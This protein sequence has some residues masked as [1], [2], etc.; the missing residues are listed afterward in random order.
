M[1]ELRHQGRLHILRHGEAA[2]P[3]QLPTVIK[4]A[5]RQPPT[6]CSAAPIPC[7]RVHPHCS[8]SCSSPRPCFRQTLSAPSFRQMFP[9]GRQTSGHGRDG[10]SRHHLR[11]ENCTLFVHFCIINRAQL[12]DIAVKTLFT[13]FMSIH[14]KIITSWSDCLFWKN[15][16]ISME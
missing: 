8:G 10:R 13:L 2:A 7:A 6:S 14:G 3:M 15:H 16:L 1:E 4:P 9:H 5:I 11:P 12:F